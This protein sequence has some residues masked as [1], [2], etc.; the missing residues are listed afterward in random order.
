MSVASATST[1]KPP[2]TT[3]PRELETTN[4]L[5]AA[6]EKAGNVAFSEKRPA[7][8]VLAAELHCERGEQCALFGCTRLLCGICTIRRRK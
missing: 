4:P 7:F 8:G 1:A 2:P 3:S 5:E 6:A